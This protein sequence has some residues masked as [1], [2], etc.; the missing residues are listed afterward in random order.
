[1][2]SSK[3]SDFRIEGFSLLKW[4]Q[5]VK[6]VF[7][8]LPI[9]QIDYP[10]LRTSQ[11][12]EKDL[13][14]ALEKADNPE[15]GK[16]IWREL[17]TLEF[18]NSVD[19]GEVKRK[20]ARKK[21][22]GHKSPPRRFHELIVIASEQ[23]KNDSEL[24]F[25]IQRVLTLPGEGELPPDQESISKWISELNKNERDS[26][27]HFKSVQTPI[28]GNTT[29]WINDL[30]RSAWSKLLLRYSSEKM[31]PRIIE[32]NEYQT[33]KKVWD[34]IIKIWGSRLTK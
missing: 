17:K 21:G 11:K 8:S 26:L 9:E 16:A 13:Q 4:T 24:Q 18:Q 30:K 5:E 28:K 14:L 23:A 3:H 19:L 32:A 1:M 2:S 34:H 15:L 27:P 22:K 7:F 31:F 20:R 12:K 10:K 33:K 29:F 25:E 6:K